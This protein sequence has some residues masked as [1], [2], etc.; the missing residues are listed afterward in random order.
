MVYDPNLNSWNPANASAGYQN[1]ASW[2]K[3]PDDT[4]LT[5]DI[6]STSSER[7]VPSIG[8]WIPDAPVTNSL[9]NPWQLYD[10]AGEMG[11]GLLL[12]N[13]KVFY[14]GASGHTAIYTPSGNNNPGSWTDG[15]EIPG[16]L[17]APDAPA[18]MMVNG[19]ILCAVSPPIYKDSNGK[20][21][22]AKPTS[23][24][25]YDPVFN[26][27][28]PVA[29]PTGPTMNVES[30]RNVML[31][32]PDGT[33]LYSHMDNQLYVYQPSG[34][35]LS[36]GKP[37]IASVT[38]NPDGTLHITGTLFNGISEGAA[39]GDDAQMNSNFPLVRLTDGSG[40]VLYARTFNWSSTGVQT[41]TRPVSTECSLPPFFGQGAYS[42][43]VVANGIS[44]DPVSFYSPVWVDFNYNGITQA[45]FFVWPFKTLAQGVSAV[46]PG[47]TILIKSAG[48]S[49]ETMTITKPMVIGAIAGPATIGQ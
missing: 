39:Y 22:W 24:F 12:Q 29:G 20:N 1:E 19:K 28:N 18:A 16:G 38:W 17:A 33:V 43:Q 30:F 21:Q 10:M 45:G 36:A 6:S 15:A 23:F 5:I 8:Q 35:P 26:S 41:G 37:A 49:Q 48:S 40:D 44:S 31:A 34:A 13:G 27:F 7:F 3:L 2:V 46:S 14:L 11:A 4:I 25:E 42:L 32:L 9:G 47:G